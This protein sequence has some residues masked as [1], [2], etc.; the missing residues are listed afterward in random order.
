[1]NQ[2]IVLGPALI[3]SACAAVPMPEPAQPQIVYPVSQ[4]SSPGAIGAPGE[5]LF[6]FEDAK[7]RNI[8]DLVTILL[9][10]KTTAQKSATTSTSKDDSLGIGAATLFG[11]GINSDSSVDVNRSFDGKGDSSQSNKLEGK[12]TVSVIQRLPNGNLVIRGEKQLQ[13][14]QGMEFVRLEGVVRPADI[15]PDNTVTS[16]R[17]ANARVSYA[18]RGALADSNAQGWLSRFF[19]SPWMPF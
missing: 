14:N 17:I 3:L 4:M 7:S 1:M 5:G 10:E 2:I 12:L 18:G 15:G 9:V 8:G 11:H 6:L 13:L 19:S 16:D